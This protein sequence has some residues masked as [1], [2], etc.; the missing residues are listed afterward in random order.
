VIA[1]LRIVGLLNA[2]AWF[3]LAV[4]MAFGVEAGA[5]SQEME[6]ALGIGNFPYF[7]GMIAHLFI[8]RLLYF[9]LALGIIALLHLGAERLYFGRASQK[10]WFGLI[11]ALL[12]ICLLNSFWLQPRL[13][14]LHK[15]AFAANYRPE[16][17]RAAQESYRGWH[18]AFKWLAVLSAGGLAIYLLRVA[19]PQESTRFLVGGSGPFQRTERV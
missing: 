6:G 13:E 14:Y 4:V 12:V 8:K 7:S 5:H 10:A 11:A 16:Q 2:A 3:G 18:M 17:R 19:T 15:A 1:F 9:Q